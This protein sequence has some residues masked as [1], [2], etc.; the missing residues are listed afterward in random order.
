MPISDHRNLNPSHCESHHGA[1]YRPWPEP[2]PGGALIPGGAPC[3]GNPLPPGG[4]GKLPPGGG[5][6]GPPT[7]LGLPWPGCIFGR[8]GKPPPGRGGNWKFGGKPPGGGNGRLPAPGGGIGLFVPPAEALG[9]GKGGGNGRRPFGPGR[10]I[11][12]VEEYKMSVLLDF[13]FHRKMS[14]YVAG[15]ELVGNHRDHQERQEP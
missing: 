6:P 5:N 11:P 2:I 15:R 1:N 3:P 10:G 4:G 9:S 13:G 14:T 12:A 7:G 8:G